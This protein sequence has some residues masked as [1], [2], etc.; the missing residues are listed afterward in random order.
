MPKENLEGALQD[1]ESQLQEYNLPAD[2]TQ[3][4]DDP[5]SNTHFAISDAAR[6]NIVAL[7]LCLG[8]WNVFLATGENAAH[9]LEGCGRFQ[10]EAQEAYKAAAQVVDERISR[11]GLQIPCGQTCN[12]G[13]FERILSV[14]RS[15]HDTLPKHGLLDR[16][17]ASLRNAVQDTIVSYAGQE[18]DGGKGGVPAA[19]EALA[20][21]AAVMPA[22]GTNEEAVPGESILGVRSREEAL[23]YVGINTID[24]FLGDDVLEMWYEIEDE[25]GPNVR[26]VRRRL[27][28]EAVNVYA[29]EE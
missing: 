12:V 14:V 17:L 28:Y 27:T 22:M 1:F 10:E 9:N 7:R 2:K 18:G 29:M 3:E 24:A 4:V 19:Q 16:I 25:V 20:N 15:A 21:A 13:A 11:E 26:N 5:T 23:N 8:F 6:L